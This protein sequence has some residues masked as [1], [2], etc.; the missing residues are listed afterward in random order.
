MDALPPND[1]KV[2]MT[3]ATGLSFVWRKGLSS[4]S[5]GTSCDSSSDECEGGLGLSLSSPGA[6]AVFSSQRNLARV[7]GML[8]T[9]TVQKDTGD[10][11]AKIASDRCQPEV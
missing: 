9:S 1:S 2:T 7:I 8:G 5:P 6:M 11:A 10:N 3:K 4:A